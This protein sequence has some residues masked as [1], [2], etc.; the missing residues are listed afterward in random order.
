[1]VFDIYALLARPRGVK[2]IGSG[3]ESVVGHWNVNTIL[4]NFSSL[5]AREVV[6]S[7][8]FGAASDENFS[9]WHYF[10]FSNVN[11]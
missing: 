6:I 8:T 9:K 3:Y 1:M 10:C 11:V 5:A 7:T 2:D 4:I